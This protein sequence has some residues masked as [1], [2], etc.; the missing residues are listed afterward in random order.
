MVESSEGLDD[1]V[2]QFQKMHEREFGF[3]LQNRKIFIDN[4]RVRSYG[5]AQ[6][7]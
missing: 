6:I 2:T 1:Y 4:V 5:T 3:K 7:I